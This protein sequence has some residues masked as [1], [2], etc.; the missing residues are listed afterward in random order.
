[1]S[2]QSAEGASEET[3]LVEAALDAIL[4]S[5]E[6]SGADRLKD[7]LK[8][9]VS[10]DLA[11]R[12]EALRAKTIAI[13]VYH[14]AAGQADAENLVR[15][16]AGRL[17]RRLDVYYA[18]SGAA[19][20]LRIHIDRGGYTPRYARQEIQTPLPSMPVK[21]EGRPQWDW[22]DVPFGVKFA[23]FAAIIA[24]P[25]S[26]AMLTWAYHLSTRAAPQVIVAET[27]EDFDE[28]L[29]RREILF[30]E[31]PERL[32]A[33]NLVEQGLSMLLPAPDQVRTQA[34]MI[35]F[36]RAALLD[37]SYAGAPAALA[38]A[39]GLRA[40]LS[41][42]GEAKQAAL[43]TAEEQANAALALDATDPLSLTARAFYDFLVQDYPSAKD[44][45]DRA[46]KIDPTNGHV[47]DYY[48]VV[49]LFA[50]DLETTLAVSDP[51]D[52]PN[53]AFRRGATQ[54]ARAT[55]MLL[56]DQPGEAVDILVQAAAL[57]D[58]ISVINHS[59]LA[60]AYQ[61]DGQS[62]KAKTSQG[63]MLRAWPDANVKGLFRQLFYD[64]AHAELII[65]YL[66]DIS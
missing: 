1:M 46:L 4:V 15:V 42:P 62:Q 24:L 2:E 20:P 27:T 53:N 36:E 19:D 8:H 55:A 33:L 25:I 59:V 45:L 38:I 61:A 29:L 3:N 40:G 16:D 60:A 13:D 11:G 50:G 18:G 66:E 7:F 5:E 22:R 41:P 64:P 26:A 49:S 32:Q 65:G 14:R 52:F 44:R 23:L 6:F 58:P 9:V 12:G 34:G 43:G 48:A 28:L 37:P 57:G 47:R 56:I 39:S 21:D 31:A 35:L 30:N 63:R 17:R 54:N 10:E 51:E